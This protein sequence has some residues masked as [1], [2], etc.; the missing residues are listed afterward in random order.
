MAFKEKIKGLSKYSIVTSFLAMEVFAFIA[1]SFGNSFILFGALS[2]ALLVILILFSIFE[3]KK[4]GLTDALIL[5]F[6]LFIYTLL[7]A[8][9]TYMRS[10]V[11][12]GDYSVGEDVFIPIGILSVALCGYLLAGNKSFKLK[13][14]LIVI[15]S[16]LSVLVLIN[17]IANIV[18]FGAFY[19]VIYK[20][21]YMYF[22]GKRSS[23]PVNEIAYTLEGFKLVEVIMS[24]YVLYPALLLTSS[25][26]L[27]TTSF[28]KEKKTFIIFLIFTLVAAFALLL[29]PSKLGLLVTLLAL[30]IDGITILYTKVE[31]SRKPLRIIMYV[32]IAIGVIIFLIMLANNQ[33]FLS[34]ISNIIAGNRYLNRL[35]NS[36]GYISPLNM[37]IKNVIG[38]NFLGFATQ[39]TYVGYYEEVHL[40][41]SF[42]FDTFMTAGVVGVILLSFFLI[43]LYL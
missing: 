25:F 36:N 16:A 39:E 17:L 12:V 15:Y 1:F 22:M 38:V 23:L 14:F 11:Y 20:G 37:M 5:V 18:N 26:A 30:G 4:E 32:V 10:H 24:Q 31:K 40:S 29:V 21:Y 8:L 13:T 34:G 43:I 35:F 33:S 6:P 7:T 27:F 3:I 28:R 42:F 41:G 2:L 9:G 19:P